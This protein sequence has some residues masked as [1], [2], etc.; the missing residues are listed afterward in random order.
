MD[1]MKLEVG[2]HALSLLF[3]E[4]LFCLPLSIKELIS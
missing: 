4:T 2:G 3:L 1:L